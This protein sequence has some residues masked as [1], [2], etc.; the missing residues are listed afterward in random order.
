MFLNPVLRYDGTLPAPAAAVDVVRTTVQ[1][2]VM[3]AV[4]FGL[5]LVWRARRRTTPDATRTLEDS[6]G[7]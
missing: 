7:P 2:I 6:K 4:A 3:A 5:L 1:R